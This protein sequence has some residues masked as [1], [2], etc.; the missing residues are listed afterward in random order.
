M[1]TSLIACDVGLKRIGLAL[2]VGGVILPLEPIVR[3]NR[4]QASQALQTLLK[5]R[6]PE[7]LLVGLP[8]VRY[9]DTRKRVLHFMSLVNFTPVVYVD[10]ENSSEQAL[11]HTAHL[12]LM[13]RQR[14]R[15][16]GV[17]D[18]LSAC[19][20]LERYLKQA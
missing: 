4:Q 16:N 5:T 7:K 3:T 9:E 12:P 17:L 10:E 1:S 19:V 13:Q 11:E 14:A 2:C 20:I 6:K 15:K 18:S 8:H